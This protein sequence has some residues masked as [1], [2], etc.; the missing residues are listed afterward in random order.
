[1]LRV[2]DVFR[3]LCLNLYRF[4][5]FNSTQVHFSVLRSLYTREIYLNLNVILGIVI[6]STQKKNKYL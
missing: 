5:S 3:R 2:L 1:M 6:G 4:I